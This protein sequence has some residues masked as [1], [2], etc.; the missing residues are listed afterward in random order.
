MKR[1]SILL[2]IAVGFVAPLAA[3]AEQ[4][5]LVADTT[6]PQAPSKA[7]RVT[8]TSPAPRKARRVWYEITNVTAVGSHLPVVICHCE[9]LMYTMGG[10]FAPSREY[11][12]QRGG[13]DVTGS[14]TVGGELNALEPASHAGYQIHGV[15]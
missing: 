11:R 15:H 1:L 7:D 9:G 4:I 13:I 10:S 12:K 14:D 2:G 3:H 8:V 6:V 5:T